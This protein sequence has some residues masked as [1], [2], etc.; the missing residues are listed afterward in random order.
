MDELRGF[1]PIGILEE[2]NIGIM[3]FKKNPEMIFPSNNP[4]FHR[5]NIPSFQ[6]M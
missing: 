6:L 4:L 2:W 3:G 1:A 5:S